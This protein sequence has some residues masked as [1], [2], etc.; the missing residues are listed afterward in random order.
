MIK[1]IQGRPFIFDELLQSQKARNE[2]MKW[3]LIIVAAIGSTALGL[4]KPSAVTNLHLIIL[5]I[6]LTCV[7][8]DLLCRN[9]SLRSLKINKFTSNFNE[10]E[11]RNIDIEYYKFYQ[12][13]KKIDS[14]NSL[15]S[16]ALIWS[17]ILLTILV[18]IIGVLISDEGKLKSLFIISGVICL[19]SNFWVERRYQIEKNII[20]NYKV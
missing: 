17:T 12:K 13:L 14:G 10:N 11:S 5:L 3:K 9:L 18:T 4:I 1:E 19:L 2:L 16:V 8:I 6:P 20:L 7:Y 15:E